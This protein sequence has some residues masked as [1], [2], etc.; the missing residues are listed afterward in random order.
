MNINKKRPRPGQGIEGAKD[1]ASSSLLLPAP[2]P[3]VNP[4]SPRLWS[5]FRRYARNHRR[6]ARLTA[7]NEALLERLR[8]MQGA[9]V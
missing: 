1:D 4:D 6:I 2:V 9:N 3:A 7:E 5:A 8:Q